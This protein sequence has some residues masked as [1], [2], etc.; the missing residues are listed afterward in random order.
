VEV[1]VTDGIT[2]LPSVSAQVEEQEIKDYLQLLAMDSMIMT[3]HHHATQHSL[4]G[5][6]S[7]AMV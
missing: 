6:D 7:S 3:V 5:Q 2:A 1:S 4:C